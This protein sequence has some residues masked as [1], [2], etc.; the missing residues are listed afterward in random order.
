[1][2][3]LPGATSTS[4]TAVTK[5]ARLQSAIGS[6]ALNAGDFE[7]KRIAFQEFLDDR[8]PIGAMC[9]VFRRKNRHLDAAASIATGRLVGG[10]V[11]RDERGRWWHELIIDSRGSETG[12]VEVVKLWVSV[13]QPLGGGADLW[14]SEVRTGGDVDDT[15]RLNADPPEPWRPTMQM[16]K[17]VTEAYAEHWPVPE[18]SQ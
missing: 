16:R 15:L 3:A 4:S 17:E 11:E 7:L 6:S 13:P 18:K 1:M 9:A 5:N 8:F 2:P 14:E 12:E 10:A